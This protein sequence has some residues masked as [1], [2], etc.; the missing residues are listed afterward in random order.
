MILI[1]FGLIFI[2]NA[3]V[4]DEFAEDTFVL[5]SQSNFLGVSDDA[6]G[7]DMGLYFLPPL[8]KQPNFSGSFDPT[9]IPIVE[10]SEDFDFNRIHA[11]FSM[12]RTGPNSIQLNEEQYK[13][14]WKVSETKA[15]PGTIYRIR[16]R[17]GNMVLGYADVGVVAT[18]RDKV[19]EGVH[20]VVVKQTLPIKFRIEKGYG[21][22]ISQG[23]DVVAFFD[24]NFFNFRALLNNNNKRLVR[25]LINYSTTG[26]RNTA[27]QVM[28][29]CGKESIFTLSPN[30]ACGSS[31]VYEPL[32]N[33]IQSE[34]YS[35]MDIS[36]TAGSIQ[37]IPED[38]KVLFLWVPQ[39]H[40]TLSEINVLKQFAQEGGRIV[41]IG[42]FFGD[43]NRTAVINQL[44]LNLGVSIRDLGDQVDCDPVYVVILPETSIRPHP[45]TEG[46]T[47]ITMG[48]SSVAEVGAEATPL[49]YDSSNTKILV[50][51][52]AIKTSSIS[53]LEHSE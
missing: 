30:S 10:I 20:R 36:S 53:A 46:I 44:M 49:I 3:C 51:V 4:E 15:K 32:R 42:E 28:F 13:V 18:G 34:G 2:T 5:Y 17:V 41:Y 8:V 37:S 12:G 48:C 9:A 38:V 16:V 45:I 40:F 14:N 50:G 22:G 25:N 31:F 39:I 6:H 19:P 35:I 43:D 23:G 29:D 52:E 33:L 7:G 47:D 24:T 11:S 1:L 27:K 26:I 21:D